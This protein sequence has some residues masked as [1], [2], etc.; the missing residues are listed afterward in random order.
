MTNECLCMVEGQVDVNGL[1][2]ICD[3][4][5]CELDCPIHERDKKLKLIE[6]IVDDALIDYVHEPTR[7]EIRT[8]HLKKIK[9]ILSI[10][11]DKKRLSP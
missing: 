1:Q 2:L 7:N 3:P 5:D 6:T 10:D 8:K 9:Q 11:S 4:N